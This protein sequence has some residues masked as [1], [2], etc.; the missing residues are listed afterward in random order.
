M[1][2][3]FNALKELDQANIQ[4]ND[5]IHLRIQQRNGKKCITTVEGLKDTKETPM[6]EIAQKMRKTFNCS[7]SIVFAM[8]DGV[9]NTKEKCIQLS[10][11]KR[12]DIKKFLIDFKIVEENKI[13]IHG[14]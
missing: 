4:A 3:L 1:D 2:E 14:Y 6:K 11:D 10:G 8:V 7:A 12:N 5:M 13:K 9:K